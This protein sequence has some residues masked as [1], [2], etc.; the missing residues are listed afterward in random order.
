MFSENLFA[1][2]YPRRSDRASIAHL[3]EYGS[4]A[5]RANGTADTEQRIFTRAPVLSERFV[6]SAAL[7]YHEIL[8]SLDIL[9]TYIR[10]VLCPEGSNACQNDAVRIRDANYVDIDY[11]TVSQS[12]TFS[13]YSDQAVSLNA[14]KRRAWNERIIKY[15]DSIATEVGVLA[16]EKSPQSEELSFGGFLVTL[17]RDT[18]P[19]KHHDS[20]CY[21]D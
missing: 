1:W 13:V 6:S 17:R 7:Q 16:E 18:K 11:D 15:A 10:K 2:L 20:S 9:I 3:L 5:T 19:S 4:P 14:G 12:F 21:A 8:P